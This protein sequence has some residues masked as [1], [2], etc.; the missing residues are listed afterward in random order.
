MAGVALSS[1]GDQV[2]R[3]ANHKVLVWDAD[4]GRDLFSVGGPGSVGSLAFCRGWCPHFLKEFLAAFPAPRRT[5]SRGS[6]SG[7]GSGDESPRFLSYEVIP[8]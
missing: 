4:S 3:R 8:G 7:P 5:T 2:G 6:R 1:D